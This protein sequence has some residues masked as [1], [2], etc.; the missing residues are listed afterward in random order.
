MDVKLRHCTAEDA[1]ALHSLSVKTFY[2]TFARYN[3]PDIM[4]EFLASA[5]D[6]E[7]LRRELS[8]TDS[9]FFFVYAD[10]NIAG[11]MKLNEAPSQSDINDKLSL[12]IERLYVLHDCHGLGLGSYMMRYAIDTAVKRGKSY[13]WLGVW[14]HNEKAKRFYKNNGFFRFDSHSFWMGDD[15]QTDILMRL[16]LK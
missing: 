15:E 1:E 12:E 4:N 11:Y 10:G 8:N 16:D 5:Y 3:P 2:D 13:V 14:E 7:K 6:T 9:S